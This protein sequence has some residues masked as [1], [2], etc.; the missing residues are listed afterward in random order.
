MLRADNI[1]P[2]MW[3]MTKW[4]HG[5]KSYAVEYVTP[6]WILSE[7]SACAL[8]A[9]HRDHHLRVLM[10]PHVYMLSFRVQARSIKRLMS[11]RASR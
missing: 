2:G 11:L 9:Y 4:N 7:S 6:V 3:A 1:H 8:H 5:G 10:Q